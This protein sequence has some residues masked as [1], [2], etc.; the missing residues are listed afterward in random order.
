MILILLYLIIG[1]IS[2]FTV[3]I[4]AMR[5]FGPKGNG[6]TGGVLLFLGTYAYLL[7]CIMGLIGWTIALLIG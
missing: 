3:L 4:F 5:Y 7:F 1:F 2:I 6:E